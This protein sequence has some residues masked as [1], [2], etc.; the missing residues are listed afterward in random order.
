MQ[1]PKDFYLFFLHFIV[2][3]YFDNSFLNST[4]SFQ[5][6]PLVVIGTI[7]LF[8]LCMFRLMF[9]LSEINL[10][11]IITMKSSTSM[12]KFSNQHNFFFLWHSSLKSELH[13]SKTGSLPLEP[14]LQPFSLQLFW[15]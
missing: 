7:T 10:V 11:Y 13:T 12:N 3:H 14:H 8:S 5:E 1:T 9:I 6:F 4:E 15:R 2:V